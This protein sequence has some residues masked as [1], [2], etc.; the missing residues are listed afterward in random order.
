[1]EGRDRRSQGRSDRGRSQRGDQRDLEQ[2]KPS[3]TQATAITATHGAADGARSHGGAR[4]D[5]SMGSPRAMVELLG[6]RAEAEARDSPV[7]ETG[8][9]AELAE[10]EQRGCQTTAVEEAGAGG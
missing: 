6:R 3:G 8:R 5:D 10:G 1:M 9:P 4:A 7:M 2:E